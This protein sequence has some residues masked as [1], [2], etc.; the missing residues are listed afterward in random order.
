MDT[1]SRTI[2]LVESGLVFQS[3]GQP[4]Y[5]ITHDHIPIGTERTKPNYN[6]HTIMLKFIELWFGKPIP[7][8]GDK[9]AE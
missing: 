9:N 2:L 3:K 7:Q 1:P 8:L 4:N 6:I 5:A